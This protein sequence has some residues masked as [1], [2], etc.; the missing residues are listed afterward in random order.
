MVACVMVACHASIEVTRVCT[1]TRLS[2][3]S[4]ATSRNLH[5]TP[6]QTGSTGMAIKSS[7]QS[8]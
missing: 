4:R 7:H 6:C 3:S 5:T 1:T 8:A 2:A